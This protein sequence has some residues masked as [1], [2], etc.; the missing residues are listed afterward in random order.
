MAKTP[1][2]P[3][4]PGKRWQGWPTAEQQ[5]EFDEDERDRQESGKPD[6]DEEDDDK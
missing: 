1:K 6:P 5:R 4:R 2:Q 3:Q